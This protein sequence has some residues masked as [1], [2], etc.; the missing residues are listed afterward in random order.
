MMIKVVVSFQDFWKIFLAK[1][2]EIN[3]K[4]EVEI[5]G[6]KYGFYAISKY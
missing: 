3:I 5:Y 4:G 1:I 6:Y 2:N